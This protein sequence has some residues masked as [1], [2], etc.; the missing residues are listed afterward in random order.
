[1]IREHESASKGKLLHLFILSNAVL[2]ED[3]KLFGTNF[4]KIHVSIALQIQTDV[5]LAI[6]TA[7]LVK[8]WNIL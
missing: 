3:E 6:L 7:W 5:W 8:E 4:L 2:V 1:M